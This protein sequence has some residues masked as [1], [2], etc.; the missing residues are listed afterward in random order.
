MGATL[1][2]YGIEPT[3]TGLSGKQFVDAVKQISRDAYEEVKDDVDDADPG[4]S[5]KQAEEVE[6]LLDEWEDATSDERKRAIEGAKDALASFDKTARGIDRTKDDVPTAGVLG[7]WMPFYQKQVEEN[8]TVTNARTKELAKEGI[9]DVG[10]KDGFVADMQEKFLNAGQIDSGGPLAPEPVRNSLIELLREKTIVRQMGATQIDLPAGGAKI[11]VQTGGSAGHWIGEGNA[12]ADSEPSYEWKRLE[13][14]KLGILVPISNDLIRRSPQSV[15]QLVSQD[16]RQTAVVEENSAL[17]FG[18]GQSGKPKGIFESTDA[19]NKFERKTDGSG[20]VTI[21]TIIKDLNM[22]AY[23]VEGSKIDPAR[24]GYAGHPRTMRYL[25]SLRGSDSLLFAQQLSNGTLL[26]APAMF[27][28]AF[29]NTLDDSGDATNDETRIAY[30]DWS[31]ALI[32]DT[33]NLRIMSSGEATVKLGGS[34]KSMLASDMTAVV[35]IH[36]VAFMLRYPKAFSWVTGVDYG[37]SYDA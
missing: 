5:E 25:M 34:W 2:D 36:E 20:N 7:R 14:D 30:G 15:E 12:P 19:G 17:L 1:E 33:L 29:P 31:Q 6:N 18:D 11:P 8:G 21:D 32:G 24:P 28:T 23:K 13:A 3:D 37:A 26:G 9:G 16:M 4:L 35:L 22:S 10:Y 27:S